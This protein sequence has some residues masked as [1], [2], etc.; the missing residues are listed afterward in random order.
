VI[1]HPVTVVLETAVETVVVTDTG[2][3]VLMIL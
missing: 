2:A 1:D 3:V